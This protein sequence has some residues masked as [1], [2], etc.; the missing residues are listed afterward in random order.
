MRWPRGL[1]ASLARPGGNITGSTYFNP[2]LS[3]KRIELLAEVQPKVRRVGVLV[4]PMNPINGPVLVAMEEAAKSLNITLE[5]F[6]LRNAP[7]F[8]AVFAALATTRFDAVSITDDSMLIANSRLAANLSAR[9][10]LPSC[11]F[12]ELARFGGL[13]GYGVN[14]RAQFY[15]ASYFIDR[16]LKGTRPEDLPVEQATKFELV[17]NLKT[18]NALGLTVPSRLLATADEVIE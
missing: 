15:R 11:G 7:E 14:F 17:I 16:I 3:V 10:R 5:N 9:H 8:A 2:E 18:A 4:N 6:P 1:V 13:V 12:A